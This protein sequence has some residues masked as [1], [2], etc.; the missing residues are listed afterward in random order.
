M[1][2][3]Q[4]TP[5]PITEGPRTWP[6]ADSYDNVLAIH[7]LLAHNTPGHPAFVTAA[8]L[9]KRAA[10]LFETAVAEQ[11]D[12]A[13]FGPVVQ[14]ALDHINTALVDALDR[15]TGDTWDVA[16]TWLDHLDLVVHA[17]PA[18]PAPPARP[19]SPFGPTRTRAVAALHERLGEIERSGATGVR[20]TDVGSDFFDTVRSRPWVA[21]ELQQLAEDGV[22]V[23]TNEDGYFMFPVREDPDTTT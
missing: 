14:T 1:T 12:Y 19:R 4:S 6:A 11:V 10:R 17:P 18:A 15:E 7:R 2:T 9:V 13:V 5:G 23:A 3:H 22:L 8:N 20:A 21:A 16:T